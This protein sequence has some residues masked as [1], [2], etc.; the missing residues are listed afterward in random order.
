MVA[1]AGALWAR[2]VSVDWP[3]YFAGAAVSRVD[4]PRY[5][6]D[7]RRYWLDPRPAAADSTG[8]GLDPAGHPLLG[9]V[10]RPATPTRCC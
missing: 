3:A 8:L 10:V 2:G 4:L 7:N 5:A 1:A 6:F 9:A